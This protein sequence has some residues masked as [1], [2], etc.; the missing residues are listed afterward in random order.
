MTEAERRKHELEE[1]AQVEAA[2]KKQKEL[3]EEE[4]RRQTMQK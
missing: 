2:I 4:R 3:E 1:K